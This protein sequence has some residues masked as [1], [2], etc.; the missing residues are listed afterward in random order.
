MLRCLSRGIMKFS[1]NPPRRQNFFELN[2][3]F[4]DNGQKDF[5]IYNHNYNYI[6]TSDLTLKDI[7]RDRQ[8]K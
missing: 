6:R 1:S 7:Q 5:D 4:P 2:P 8:L 3:I